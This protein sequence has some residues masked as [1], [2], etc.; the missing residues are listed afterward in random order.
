MSS[1]ADVFTDPVFAD[2]RRSLT[3]ILADD[4]GITHRPR[5]FGSG[6]ILT[7]PGGIDMGVFDV[8]EAMTWV[9]DQRRSALTRATGG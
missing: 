2:E 7:G 6:Q 4:F 1:I 8:V 9:R 3:A 5:Q